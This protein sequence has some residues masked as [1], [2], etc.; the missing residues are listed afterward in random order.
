MHGITMPGSFMPGADEASLVSLAE[1][2]LVDGLKAGVNFSKCGVNLRIAINISI[3][4]LAKLP[5][6]DIVRAQHP[7]LATGRA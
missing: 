5:V 7:N 3:A 6:G 1:K 4:A 2:G